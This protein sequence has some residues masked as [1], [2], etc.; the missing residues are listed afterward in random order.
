MHW[1]AYSNSG[2]FLHQILA[3]P[4]SFFLNGF[5]RTKRYRLPKVDLVQFRCNIHRHESKRFP[6]SFIVELCDVNKLILE[7]IDNMMIWHIV[8]RKN[9]RISLLLQCG[10]RLLKGGNQP[11]VMVD[12]NGMGIIENAYGQRGNQIRKEL[13]KPC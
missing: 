4:L 12:S 8:L 13:I 1:Q 11:I 9:H 5:F 7:L 10:N 2:D 6:R 3:D